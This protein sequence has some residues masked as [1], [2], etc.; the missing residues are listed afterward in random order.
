MSIFWANATQLMDILDEFC[1]DV[2]PQS[3]RV[4]IRMFISKAR[5]AQK[6]GVYLS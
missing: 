5:E 2:C 4:W 6:S 3:L 1:F